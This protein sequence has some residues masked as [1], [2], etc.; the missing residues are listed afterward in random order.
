MEKK[1]PVCTQKS[2]ILVSAAT[3]FITTFMGSAL[4]L[5]VPAI[6][7]DFQT[8]AA[9]AGWIITVYML[10]C[11]ALTVPF[12][13]IADTGR[14]NLILRWG[15]F[16]FTLACT[17]AAFSF[18]M[19]MLIICRVAQGVGASMIFSTNI[20]VLVNSEEE[21]RRGKALGYV[22]C[23]NYGGLSAGPAVGGILNHHFGWRSVFAVSA[24]IG[25]AAFFMALKKMQDKPYGGK[26]GDR[27]MDMTG[28]A[29]YMGFMIL[30]MYGL[31][32]L[33]SSGAG[34]VLLAAG[35]IMMIFFIKR[36]TSVIRPM[37]DI[38]EFVRNK[39]CTSASLA[40]MMNFGSNFGLTY[41]LSIYMQGVMGMDPQQAGLLLVV[42]PGIMSVLSPVMGKLSDK[43]PPRILSSAG[44]ILCIA[45]LLLGASMAGIMAKDSDI[46]LTVPVLALSGLG[47]A[48]F[49]AP[50]TK[51]VMSSVSSCDHG[52]T[53]SILATMRSA[54]HTLSMAVITGIIGV[55]MG[56]ESL[57]GADPR[58][59]VNIMRISFF[60]FAGLCIPGFFMALRRKP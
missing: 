13:K 11:A 12:G 60:I 5:A 9:E 36:E 23:A 25:A 27:H 35:I 24:V 28:M 45:S 38:N 47:L 1:S 48:F 6:E 21:N 10:T 16:I 19:A 56:Q 17:A 32:E 57:E 30:V 49:A 20:A 46:W 43:Y 53:S 51:E 29:L 8:G 7:R 22:T 18:N 40:T 33:L 4:N 31:S 44:M 14:K 55:Y 41:L 52:I 3:S 2:V 59:V 39:T 34:P 42:S 26:N 50:N 15:I 54:G 37:L 58:I